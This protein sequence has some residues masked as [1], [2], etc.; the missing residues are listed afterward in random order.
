M[1]YTLLSLC[2]PVATLAQEDQ[3]ADAAIIKALTERVEALEKGSLKLKKLTVT[4]HF[5]G[6]YIYAEQ[7]AQLR[8]GAPNENPDHS[9][10]RIG[11]RQGR[12]RFLFEDGIVSAFFQLD[13]TERGVAV[14]DAYGQLRDPWMRSNFL[15]GG[16]FFR[17]FGHEVRFPTALRETPERSRIITTLFPGARDLGVMMH[18]QADKSLPISM[19]ELDL[20][21]LTGNGMNAETDSKRDFVGSLA[22]TPPLGEWWNVRVGTSYYSGSVYQ[23]TPVIYRM[24]GSGFVRDAAS[25]NQGR[26][27]RRKYIGFDA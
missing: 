8:I 17:P 18:L 15:R 5:Q 11:I 3:A 10:S 12:M 16:M 1:V 23:G 20:G 21:L 19:L 9:F 25:E 2:L 22:L 6:Q 14:V 24:E 26:F 4:G 7:D 13:M 27:A